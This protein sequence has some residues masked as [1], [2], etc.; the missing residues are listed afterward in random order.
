[1]RAIVTV[2]V[3]S[4]TYCAKV[5]WD[6]LRCMVTQCISMEAFTHWVTSTAIS[7]HPIA[8][9]VWI[10]HYCGNLLGRPYRVVVHEYIVKMLPR[11]LSTQTNTTIT[12]LLYH[13]I[14]KAVE[15]IPIPPSSSSYYN[16][17]RS[18]YARWFDGLKVS[19]LVIRSVNVRCPVS[20]AYHTVKCCIP[21]YFRIC[22]QA[23]QIDS[24]LHPFLVAKSSTCLNWL[25]VKEVCH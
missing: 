11:Q 9:C 10:H 20:S 12:I 14:H 18:R 4:Y 1:M 6:G 21:Q 25:G 17:G 24:A 22:N 19:R 3:H 7:S 13:N 5:G 16:L 23:N 2:M 15:V 8:A